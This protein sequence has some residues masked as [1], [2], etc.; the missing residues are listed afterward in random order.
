VRSL[1]GN[2][3]RRHW[4]SVFVAAGLFIPL[5][6]FTSLLIDELLAQPVAGLAVDLPKRNP[7]R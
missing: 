2:A 1:C 5:D 7:F 6:R 4:Q 3:L